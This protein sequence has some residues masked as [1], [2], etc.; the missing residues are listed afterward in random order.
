MKDLTLVTKIQLTTNPKTKSTFF[1][2]CNAGD[3]LSITSRI[4][5][6]LKYVD[7][8]NYTTGKNT[9][10]L[11]GNFIRTLQTLHYIVIG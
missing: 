1:K 2:K 9:T 3:V 8:S 7:I 5:N 10:M 11:V 6:G 4:N